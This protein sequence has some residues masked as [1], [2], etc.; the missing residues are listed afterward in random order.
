MRLSIIVPI[1]N[2][3]QYIE[4]CLDSIYNQN[5]NNFEVLC[6]DDKG[7]DSSIQK[8]REYIKKNNIKNLKII[9]HSK[10]MGLSEARNTGINNAKGKYICFLDSD[11]MLEKG[12]INKLLKTAEEENLDI[13]E[14]KVIEVFETNCNIE[15]GINSVNR[16]DSMIVNGDEYF[17]D[18]V[19]NNMYLSIVCCR[20]FKRELLKN[21][22][23]FFPGIKFEDEEFSPRAIISANRIQY[24]DVP[25][26]I[27][28]RRD[29]S[30]TTNMFEDDKWY[31][32]YM[33]VI[34]SL[35]N[36][37]KLNKNKKSYIYLKNRIGQ[38]ALSILKNPIA[39]N[40]NNEQIK[41]IVIEIK[42]KK[43]YR[44]PLKSKSFFIKLQGFLMM[45]P[46]LFIFLYERSKKNEDNKKN[47]I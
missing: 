26:Y 28:R 3:E 10:N 13:V 8:V 20:L 47:C 7:K 5:L 32:S 42:N 45:F 33:K 2:V 12:G 17:S 34:N 6:I 9:E 37:S 35:D 18:T 21:K 23:Y 38:L 16:N 30:I 27:Y 4:E 29:S 1:Y 24:L 22:L 19:K 41:K 39:Y 40:A 43:I 31:V 36:Y 25:F 44:I 46:K 15:L 11:D 14:G